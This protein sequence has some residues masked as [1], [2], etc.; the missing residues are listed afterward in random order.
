VTDAPALTVRVDRPFDQV[1]ADVRA[2]LATQGFGVLTEID[3]QATLKAKI[4]V[5]MPAYLIL[6][7]CNPPLAHRALTADPH[8]GTLLPCNVVVRV[9]GDAVVVDAVD[10]GEMLRATGKPDLAPVAD[11]ATAKLTTA[12]AS[13]A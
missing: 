1:V 8:V 9:D 2:A 12:L 5:D 11:E 7:A 3:V 13:L 6:G 4:D 10:P